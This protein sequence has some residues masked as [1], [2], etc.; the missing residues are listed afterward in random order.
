[1]IRYISFILIS[2]GLVAGCVNVDSQRASLATGSPC[3]S[4]IS[5]SHAI[6]LVAPEVAVEVL[7]DSQPV[8]FKTGNSHYVVIDLGEPDRIPRYLGIRQVPALTNVYT[9]S[10]SWT[11]TFIP[12]VTFLSV[13]GAFV[14]MAQASDPAGPPVPCVRAWGCGMYTVSV[15]VPAGT[16][17][18][19]IHTD[20]RRVGET[21]IEPIAGA[22]GTTPGTMIKAGAAFVPVS[23]GNAPMS[24]AIRMASGKLEVF[25]LN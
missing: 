19:V 23:G 25:P 5:L 10:G 2:A 15:V 3:C 14:S 4:T 8:G 22:N 21:S 1:M 12:A 13:N 20:A 17:F 16:R 18:A 24:R 6:P 9:S 11:P 7:E